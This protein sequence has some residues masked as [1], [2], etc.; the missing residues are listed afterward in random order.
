MYPKPVQRPH[1]PIHFG[2]ESDAALQRVADLGQGW[3]GFNLLPDEVPPRLAELERRL[4][5]RGRSR[6]EVQV[7]VSPYLRPVDGDALR[8]YRDAGVDQVIALAVASPRD[9]TA[10][11]T[12]DALERRLDELAAQLVAPASRL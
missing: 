2:G 3:Y 11:G 1:P 12:R 7:S 4:A 6:S 8:R 9:L 5:A 10:A